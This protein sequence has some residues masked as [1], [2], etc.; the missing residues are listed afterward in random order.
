MADYGWS[1]DEAEESIEYAEYMG[2]M[3]EGPAPGEM[4]Q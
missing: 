3:V 4:R 1:E 2:A